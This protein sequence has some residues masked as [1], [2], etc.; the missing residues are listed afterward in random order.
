MTVGRQRSVSTASD[1]IALSLA[2]QPH[3]SV[4]YFGVIFNLV[5]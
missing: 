1:L 4:G 5:I 2:E 3:L